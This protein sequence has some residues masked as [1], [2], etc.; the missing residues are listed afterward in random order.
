MDKKIIIAIDGFSSTGKSTFAKLIA[1][2]LNYI[3][4]DSG[5]MY[6]ALTYYAMSAGFIGGK[7]EIK[8]EELQSSIE[9]GKLNIWFDLNDKGE[10]QTIM[11]GVS[12]EQ[13]IRKSKVSSLVSKIAELD[14]VRNFVD[15]KLR[16]IGENK[17]VVIDGRDIGT[18]VF[19]NAEIK[20]FMTATEEVRARR[21]YEELRSK[22]E[23]D[24]YES[25]LEGIRKRD[26]IDQNREIHPLKKADDALELDNSSMTI[27]E[28]IEWL[29]AILKPNFN[30]EIKF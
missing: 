1:K 6:R 10:S 16:A 29:N 28:E 12:V 24:S 26:E 25:V 20:I 11:N 18:A 17:G 14:F 7:G 15:K 27:T 8:K 4:L 9:V 19:P 3:Y 22:G 30:L 2:G 23:N 21:R 13:M 5:A